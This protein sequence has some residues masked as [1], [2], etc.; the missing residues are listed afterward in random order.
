[1]IICK[2]KIL[3]YGRINLAQD[4]N[5]KPTNGIGQLDNRYAN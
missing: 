2:I 1:M 3:W 5:E 4:H